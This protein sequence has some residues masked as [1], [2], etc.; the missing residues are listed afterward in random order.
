MAS[1]FSTW[2]RISLCAGSAAVET[3]ASVPINVR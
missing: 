3:S 2:M 1:R